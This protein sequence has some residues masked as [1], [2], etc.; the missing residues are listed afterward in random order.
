MEE[1]RKI[2]EDINNNKC[3]LFLGPLMTTVKNKGK[4]KSLTEIYCDNILENFKDDI[5][6]FDE[7]AKRNPYFLTTKYI[8]HVN[9]DKAV[10]Q[11]EELKPTFD[12]LDKLSSSV[13]FLL[14]KLPF[15][16]I[17]NFGSDRL[18][19]N[20]LKR[21][22]FEF[23]DKYYNY[24]GEYQQYIVGLEENHQLVYN[25]LG[26]ITDP[27]SQI[28]TEEDYLLFIKRIVT[29]PTLPDNLLS[30]IKEDLGKTKSY[31]FLGFNFEEWPFRFLLDVLQLPKA[32]S[33]VTSILPGY[34]IALMTQEF[35]L[36]KFGLKF[37]NQNPEE[38]A[39]TLINEYLKKYKPSNHSKGF[40]F[41]H[42]NK[43]D[44]DIVK[45]FNEFLNTSKLGKRIEFWSEDKVLAGEV[46]D[47]DVSSHFNES[48]V[49][50]PFISNKF[51]ND[52]KHSNRLKNLLKKPGVLI[53]PIIV[54]NCTYEI[55]FPEFVSPKYEIL[56]A[57]GKTLINAMAPVPSAEDY[58]KI[59]KT[60]N[61]NIR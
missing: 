32:T 2:L 48:S 39:K 46:T 4:R 38:F 28:L 19:Q 26:S 18:M 42:D 22:G 12:L 60:I 21:N 56:P 43:N 49:Y 25:L 45:E 36:E 50:I 31:V 40:I 54:S 7:A 52:P 17:I 10:V 41:Y 58:I 20:A 13:Y 51:L 55:D 57:K 3:I 53:F 23:S 24:N 6:I 33:S 35:Y 44:T 8:K 61:S 29:W 27:P 37:M 15:N 47:E 5:I 16:T 14:S 30:R 59:I 9:K 1:I 34:N 11:M